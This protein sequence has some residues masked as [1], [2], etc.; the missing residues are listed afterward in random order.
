MRLLNRLRC[1]AEDLMQRLTDTEARIRQC[2][3]AIAAL[4][5]DKARK[6]KA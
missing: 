5:A 2:H 6:G 4:K 3:D 1:A